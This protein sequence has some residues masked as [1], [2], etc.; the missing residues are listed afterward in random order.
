M[1]KTQLEISWGT[2][3]RFLLVAVAFLA[4]YYFRG[5][6]ALFLSAA[7]I[8]AAIEA[9][10]SLL[11]RRK[12]PRF[13]AVTIIYITGIIITFGLLYFV[14]PVIASQAEGTL[15]ALV[16]FIKTLP[17]PSSLLPSIYELRLK[18]VLSSIG[19]LGKGAEQALT[20]VSG[21][22]GGL[23]NL[24]LVFALSYYLSVQE[25]WV[26]KTLRVLAP[27]RYENYLIDL[28]KRAEKKIGR[29]FYAQIVLS[30]VVGVPVFIG[31]RLIGVEYALLIGIIAAALEIMPVAGPIVAGAIAF[32]IAAQQG[33]DLGVYTIILFVVVQQLENNIFVPMVMRR[34][35]G[36]NP[37]V[38]I[39]ALLVGAKLAGFWGIVIA[40]PLTA[41]AS[42]FW[43]DLEKRRHLL[44][45]ENP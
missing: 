21:I 15:A 33:I 5:L 17:L 9:P 37:A 20:I 23:F 34:S 18:E 26:E 42:E 44:P 40:V 43:I 38:V 31:L 30:F 19:S 2:A 8:A 41:A 6:I 24:I 25:G 13:A 39:F 22:F 27:P 12:W 11:M 29:W 32:L 36:L 45:D 10:A 7:V 16:V 1:E 4:L 28:W 35:T 3:A 14:V